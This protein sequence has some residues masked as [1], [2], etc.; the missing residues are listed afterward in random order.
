MSLSVEEKRAHN[1]EKQRKYREQYPDRIVTSRKKFKELHP[2]RLASYREKNRI[3]W[4]IKNPNQNIAHRI[5]IRERNRSHILSPPT[6][7]MCFS[8]NTR[9]EGHHYDYSKPLNLTWVCR[10]CHLKIHSN[11]IKE[12]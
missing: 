6:C 11:F 9:I 3:A 10:K 8:G 2:E 5:V 4:E 1:R 7:S 12:K